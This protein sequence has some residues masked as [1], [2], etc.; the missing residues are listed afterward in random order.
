LKP[1]VILTQTQCDVCAVSQRDVEAAVGDWIESRPRILSLAP[2]FFR[3]VWQD[4][5]RVGEAL[6]AYPRRI[7]RVQEQ[8]RQRTDDIFQK[9][10]QLPDRPTIACI[11][12]ID[13]LMAAGN[14]VPELVEMA[15]GVNLFGEAGKH[16]PWMTWEQLVAADPDVIALM[17]CGFDI[18]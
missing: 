8:M 17:P 14:W 3:D 5:Q 4:I 2:N 11:E 10:R 6:E 12:W 16:A 15:G 7:R 9:T 13:P 1:D 18:A